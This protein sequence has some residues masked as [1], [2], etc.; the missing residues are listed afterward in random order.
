MKPVWSLAASSHKGL[1]ATRLNTPGDKKKKKKNSVN[2]RKDRVNNPPFPLLTNSSD[3]FA[4]GHT[5]KKMC[6]PEFMDKSDTGIQSSSK[7]RPADGQTQRRVVQIKTFV[8]V[9]DFSPF[10]QPHASR[11]F[12]PRWKS[13]EARRQ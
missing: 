9:A 1:T 4:L 12:F 3:A 11:P 8:A 6:E 5:Q 13:I 2:H 7:T 10:A